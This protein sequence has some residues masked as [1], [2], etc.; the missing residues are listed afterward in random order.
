MYA[1]VGATKQYVKDYALPK[2]FNDIFVLTDE[3]YFGEF[4]EH[5][6]Y[7][8]TTSS[9]AIGETVTAASFYV[10][11]DLTFQLANKNSY[12]A[13]FNVIATANETL[14]FRLDIDIKI[15]NNYYNASSCLT[16]DVSLVANTSKTISFQSNFELLSAVYNLETG[17]ELQFRLTAIRTNSFAQTYNVYSNSVSPCIFYLYT[18]VQGILGAKVVQGLGDSTTDVISQNTVSQYITT[19]Q[20]DKENVSNKVT[21]ISNTSTD[22]QYPS[23]KCVFD[24]IKNVREVA[25]GKC[26]TYIT[27]YSWDVA[28]VKQMCIDMGYIYKVVD[29]DGID[30][31]QFIINGDYDSYD[32]INN[33]FNT[34]DASINIYN[35]MY[36]TPAKYLFYESGSGVATLL[37]VDEFYG[38]LK[39]GDII[40]LLNT[41]VPDRW[42]DAWYLALQKLETSKVDLTNYAQKGK[43][44][45]VT[46]A[47][48]DWSSNIATK[49]FADLGTYDLIQFYPATTTDKTNA[50]N[51]DIFVSASGSTVTFTATNTPTA[52]ITFNYF[53]SQGRS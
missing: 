39:N 36:Q 8:E 1:D 15:G 53:I 6:D 49:T 9:S 25:E 3:G 18:N 42:A 19:L 38:L 20:S 46:I 34:Q 7:D 51:A 40:L 10:L 33:I 30:I 28:T 16:D 37:T 14:K 29:N 21:A 44:G 45:S 27:D 48:S 43:S 50:S 26:K 47:T 5:G 2:Q 23:A 13:K 22:T 4:G 32:V 11:G 12:L 52:N 35:Y 17:N 24:N 31:T 41:D